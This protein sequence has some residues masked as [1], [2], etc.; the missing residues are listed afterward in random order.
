M[1]LPLVGLSWSRAPPSVPSGKGA[2]APGSSNSMPSSNS[3]FRSV[4]STGTHAR[5]APVPSRTCKFNCRALSPAV[6]SR[7]PAGSV[8]RKRIS[9]APVRLLPVF[10]ST[11]ANVTKSPASMFCKLLSIG[12]AAKPADVTVPVNDD[13]EPG[14]LNVTPAG[15]TGAGSNT[16]GGRG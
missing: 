16:A 10:S 3:G 2:V 13:G 6:G 15:P 9:N 14:G 11:M 4:A 8:S 5:S 12:L 1:F 7:N